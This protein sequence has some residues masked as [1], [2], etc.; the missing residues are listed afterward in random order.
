MFYA[1]AARPSQ[2][3]CIHYFLSE[4][5]YFQ[6]SLQSIQYFIKGKKAK[7]DN[8]LYFSF[9][10]EKWVEKQHFKRKACF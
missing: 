3:L 1:R 10:F 9:V 6:T 5:N 7:L 4:L 2:K 8:L